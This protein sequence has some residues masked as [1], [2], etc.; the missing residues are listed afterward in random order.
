MFKKLTLILTSGTLAEAGEESDFIT[1][2]LLLI[3]LVLKLLLLQLLAARL[4]VLT[5]PRFLVLTESRHFIHFT[6]LTVQLSSRPA[7]SARAPAP[8][9]RGC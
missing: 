6:K 7:D 9:C 8:D 5:K 2:Y 3:L 1:V 4:L